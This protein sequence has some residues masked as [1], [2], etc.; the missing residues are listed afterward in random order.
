MLPQCGLLAQSIQG[1]TQTLLSYAI[2][3]PLIHIK[4]YVVSAEVFCNTQY[5]TIIA[6]IRLTK[7]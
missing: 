7:R 3:I 1:R 5:I 4:R 2:L 6:Q